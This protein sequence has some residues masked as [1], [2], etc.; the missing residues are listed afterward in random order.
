M[1]ALEALTAGYEAARTDPQFQAELASTLRHYVGR[2]TPLYFARR[3]SERLGGPRIYLKR[4]D[5]CHTGAHKINN[6]VGQILLAQ[7]P[8]QEA[9][10]RRDRGRPARR[11]DRH[12]G[13]AARTAVRGLHGHRGHA[14]PGASTWSACGCW[15]PRS[16]PVDSGSRTLKDA[17]NE[18]MRDWVT[19]VR[20]HALRA[21]LRA[22]GAPLPPHGARLPGDHRRR[23]APRRSWKPKGGCRIAWWPAWAAAATPSGCSSGSS[24]M[25]GCA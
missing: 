20:D 15:G 22:R 14:A 11:G 19:N 2:P 6:T 10:H 7:T 17:I 8:G 21:G 16:R 24:A 4:E 9:D 13:G 1:A 23:G 3:L 18:A 12:R 25:R 5:L